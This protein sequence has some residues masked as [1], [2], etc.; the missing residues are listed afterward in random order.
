MAFVF[1]SVSSSFTASFF[2]SAFMLT[3]LSLRC[4]STSIWEVDCFRFPG[5]WSASVMRFESSCTSALLSQV[6]LCFLLALPIPLQRDLRWGAL[7]SHVFQR[8][9]DLRFEEAHGQCSLLVFWSRSWL[10][11][12]SSSRIAILDLALSSILSI[13]KHFWLPFQRVSFWGIVWLKW[14][15]S[16]SRS[17]PKGCSGVRKTAWRALSYS[18]HQN[19][20]KN[21]QASCVVKGLF[22]IVWNKCL[23]H[24][25]WTFWNTTRLSLNSSE[26]T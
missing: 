11:M 9:L 19:R 21:S 12:F 14:G 1:V 7:V 23:F 20:L 13:T 25:F 10:Q 15:F 26:I 2:K 17:F 18:T 6:V 4:V 24:Q 5:A 8:V 16:S 22:P 3:S